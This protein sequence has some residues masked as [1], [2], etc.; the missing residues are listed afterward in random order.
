MHETVKSYIIWFEE[1]W[2]V[3]VHPKATGLLQE[4][5]FW[6]EYGTFVFGIDEDQEIYNIMSQAFKID[7]NMSFLSLLMQLDYSGP[8]KSSNFYELDQQIIEQRTH[9]EG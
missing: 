2:M 7:P 4:P 3:S 1:T 8:V 9:S 5:F 6:N